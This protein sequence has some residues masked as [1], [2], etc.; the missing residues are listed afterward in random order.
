[1]P[2]SCIDEQTSAVAFP[3]QPGH[4]LLQV[5]RPKIEP[6]SISSWNSL[7]SH[8]FGMVHCVNIVILVVPFSTK[9]LHTDRILL[10]WI[11]AWKQHHT[12]NHSCKA[13]ELRRFFINS[14]LVAVFG[15]VCTRLG[16]KLCLI[17]VTQW[18]INIYA[19]LQNFLSNENSVKNVLQLFLIPRSSLLLLKSFELLMQSTYL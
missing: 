7:P 18:T 11:F 16:Q 4:I 1:M 2:S 15:P 9:L 5:L 17:D 14:T 12:L 3:L 10:Q 6:V 19:W 8:L 13:T